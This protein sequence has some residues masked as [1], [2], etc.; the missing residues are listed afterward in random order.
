MHQSESK[1]IQRYMMAIEDRVTITSVP[2][3]SLQYSALDL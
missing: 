1:I 3:K 2:D